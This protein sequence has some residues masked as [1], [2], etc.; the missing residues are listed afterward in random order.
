MRTLKPLSLALSALLLTACTTG[1]ASVISL[2]ADAE[3]EPATADTAASAAPTAAPDPTAA[4]EPTAAPAVQWAVE[5][6]ITADNIDVP[7]MERGSSNETDYNAYSLHLDNGLCV[8]ESGGRYGLIDYA[9]NLVVP[10]EY[11]EITVGING[12]YAL[13]QDQQNYFTLAGDGSLTALGDKVYINVLGTAPN[14]QVYWVPDR[15]AMYLSGGVDTYLEFPYT[16]SAPVAAQ[17]VTAVEYECATAWDGVVLTDGA[18]PVTDTRYEAAGGYRCGLI[19]VRQDGAWGYLDAQGQT[20]LP[21]EF[22]ANWDLANAGLNNPDLALPYGAS[23]GYIVVSRDGQDALYT[24]GGECV[25]DFGAYEELRPVHGDKLWAR[26]NGQWGVLQ[27]TAGLAD[28]AVYAAPATGVT[29]APDTAQD[30]AVVADADSGLVLRAGPGTDYE[31]LGA[32]PSGTWMQVQGSS[33]AVSGWAYVDQGGWVS[34]EY[35]LA[36]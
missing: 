15:G 11:S 32:V 9:G 21:F 26:Q 35:L 5:P 19:P 2:P 13:T 24:V 17:V 18:A 7:R 14:R 28:A 6:T 10:A 29:V 1:T 8:V 34:E 23:A 31:R 33:S 25:I 4:P 22:E 20:V 30:R 27:L 12:R 3:S 36:G 16:S